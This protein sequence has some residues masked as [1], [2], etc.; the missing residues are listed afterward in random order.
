MLFFF[1]FFGLFGGKAFGGIGLTFSQVDLSSATDSRSGSHVPSL[2]EVELE[3]Y[4]IFEAK[5]T[6]R[7]EISPKLHLIRKTEKEI[8]RD[9][10]STCLNLVACEM[11]SLA[12][13]W[14]ALYNQYARDRYSSAEN[15][16]KFCGLTGVAPEVAEMIYVKYKSETLTRLN[17]F[18]VL[19]YLKTNKTEDDACRFFGVSRLTYRRVLW[20]T[21]RYLAYVMDEVRMD[22][23]FATPP[24][25]SSFFQNAF[26]VV[27]G[28]DC[29]L[30]RPSKREDRNLYSNG[31]S[32]EN[33]KSRYNLKYTIAVQIVTGKI[34][35]I[36]GISD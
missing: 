5:F 25:E 4:F 27:D 26:L 6:N 13:P 33:I 9:R 20:A 11:E 7:S 28:T 15:D 1:G 23:R 29:P 24:S 10:S 34:C 19:V 14:I 31:R 3:S 8:I 22:Q 30:R 36:S 35:F 21:I 2:A 12:R 32:K 17:L 18:V 16:R